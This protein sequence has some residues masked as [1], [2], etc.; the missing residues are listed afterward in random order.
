ME[1][2]KREE[3]SQRESDLLT[4]KGGKLV[5]TKTLH[6]RLTGRAGIREGE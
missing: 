3:R 2:N 1:R 5:S 6:V 4:L